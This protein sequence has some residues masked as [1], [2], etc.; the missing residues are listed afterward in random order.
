MT[1][2]KPE[3]STAQLSP[4]SSDEN[5]PTSVPTYSRSGLPGATT[6]VC[7]GTSGRVLPVPSMLAKVSPP[8]TER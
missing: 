1:L 4:P 2:A 6:I 3:F 7:V 8:S 5:T